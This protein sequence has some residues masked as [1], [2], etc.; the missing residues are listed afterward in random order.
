MGER[1]LS[2]EMTPINGVSEAEA[3]PVAVRAATGAFFGV[4]IVD[5][6][7]LHELLGELVL[8]VATLG[9]LHEA[10]ALATPLVRVVPER[11]L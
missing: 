8:L 3:R 6:L 4:L 10:G 7:L 9:S 2:I 5:A 1:D 11:V